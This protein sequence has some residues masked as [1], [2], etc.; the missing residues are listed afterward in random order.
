[1]RLIVHAIEALHNRLLN[2]VDP[3]CGFPA[4]GIYFQDRVVVNLR[5]EVL[6]PAAVAAEPRAAVPSVL[7][8][9][10]REIV[11]L[12]LGHKDSFSAPILGEAGKVAQK[13][14]M[15]RP[16]VAV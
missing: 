15:E 11:G 14:A 3:L 1:V 5:L 7:E 4:E 10:I 9:A 16:E 2:L 13:E 6:R 8:A 12:G